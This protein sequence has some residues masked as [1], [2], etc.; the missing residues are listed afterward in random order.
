MERAALYARVSS[1]EQVEGYSIDAQRR[2]FKTLCESK[3]WT[4]YQEYI[5]EGK[6]AHND[7]I[8]NRPAFK[9]IINDA[10]ARK[11]D[12]FVVHKLDR[13]SRHLR[14]TLEYFDRLQKAGVSF[15]SISEQMDFTNPMGKV[16]LALLGAF[17]QYY[18]DNLSQET[19]KGWAERRAQGY[20]CGLLPFGVMKG[21]DGIPVPN[22][23]TYPG[24][25]MAYELAA[26]GK[27]DREVAVAMNTSGYRTAGNQ[28]NRPFSKDTVGG[29]LTNKFYLGYLPDGDHGWIKAKHSPLIETGLFYVVQRNRDARKRPRLT[30]NIHSRIYSLT[31][32]MWCNKCGAKMRIQTNHN[33]R[34]RIYCAGKAEGLGC[35]NKGTFLDV[36]EKQIQWYLEYFI[37]PE[38][39]Q[40]KILEAHQKLE[41]TCDDDGRQKQVLQS[42]LQRIKELFKWGHISR[43]EYLD[44]YDKIQQKFAETNAEANRHDTL[45]KLAHFLANVAGAWKQ[46]TQEQRHKLA[47]SLFEQIKVE[48]KR[49]VFVKPRPELQPFFKLSFE[50]HVKDI[51]GDPEGI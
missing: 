49:V 51:A 45:G 13:F 29:I 36:Y 30:V 41:S 9:S 25:I 20:Y 1:E 3:G 12:V 21:E 22:P 23:N 28:G 33:G 39:Y 38:N 16:Q 15:V 19:K 35:K 5:D 34:P 4:P 10:L 6:S 47:M 8:D 37:I 50:C 7:N 17:A 24:L 14:V 44:E 46:A 31:A 27:T 48:E 42:S 43:E 2:A 26:S 32:M 40:Q 11:F 18:S